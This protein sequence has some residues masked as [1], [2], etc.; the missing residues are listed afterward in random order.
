MLPAVASNAQSAWQR[1]GRR[2]ACVVVASRG[3]FVAL[4][5]A[6]VYRSGFIVGSR[7]GNDIRPATGLRIGRGGCGEGSRSRS[8]NDQLASVGLLTQKDSAPLHSWSARSAAGA[9]ALTS[10]VALSGAMRATSRLAARTGEAGDSPGAIRN[11]RIVVIVAC[12]F[13]IVQYALLQIFSVYSPELPIS[14][15]AASKLYGAANL[16]ATALAAPAGFAFD[17]LG[18]AVSSLLGGVLSVGGLTVAA[19]S[20]AAMGSNPHAMLLATAGCLMFGFGTTLLN[21]VAILS[22]IRAAPARHAGKVS[23]GV[24]C[25]C[26]LGMSLHTWIHARWFHGQLYTFFVYQV[27]YSLLAGLVG[28]LLFSSGVWRR[29]LQSDDEVASPLPENDSVTNTSESGSTRAKILNRV[30]STVSTPYFPWLTVLFLSPMAY[31]FALIGCWSVCAGCLGVRGAQQ[32]QLAL[33]FGLVSAAGRIC[34]GFFGDWAPK[35]KARLGCELGFLVSLCAFQ[36]GFALLE[37]D[38]LAWFVPAI[39]LQSF[40]FGGVIALVPAALKAGFKADDLGTAYGLLYQLLAVTF[41]LFNRAAVPVTGLT[42]PICFRGWFRTAAALNA[43]C[44]AWAACRAWRSFN[45]PTMS[46]GQP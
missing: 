13:I 36:V 28:C 35:G 22:A 37:L 5:A 32:S 1:H 15:G 3:S 29:A 14:A 9:T 11:S 6:A 7:A 38:Q 30:R 4:A 33:C 31:A 27:V 17:G 24:M 45:Q 18:P 23:A 41:T 10:A 2:R 16:G 34:F 42:G 21:T 44:V 46:K 12:C 39:L 43:L 8:G 20:V 26:S 25:S 19:M 40:G